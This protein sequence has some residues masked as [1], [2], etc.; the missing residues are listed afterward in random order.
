[1]CE[2]RLWKHLTMAT[3]SSVGQVRLKPGFT[4][5][6]KLYL[7]YKSD[8]TFFSFYCYVHHMS[9]PKLKKIWSSRK[10]SQTFILKF[11]TQCWQVQL[12]RLHLGKGFD[13]WPRWICIVCLHSDQIFSK[14]FL[15]IANPGRWSSACQSW[16]LDPL[17]Q[18]WAAVPCL[19]FWVGELLLSCGCLGLTE[20]SLQT[21]VIGKYSASP[22]LSHVRLGRPPSCLGYFKR[23]EW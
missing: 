21:N 16:S 8:R 12:H 18:W 5:Y 22:V 7:Q 2:K 10:S 15:D 4:I 17:C 23:Y 14:Q 6:H 1:M 13:T 9:N 11:G 19:F 3:H 20:K